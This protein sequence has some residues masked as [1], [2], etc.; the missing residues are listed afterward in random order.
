MLASAAA[1]FLQASKCDNLVEQVA[2][3]TLDA[4]ECCGVPELGTPRHNEVRVMTEHRQEERQSVRV[5]FY[6]TPEW[7]ARLDEAVEAEGLNQRGPWVRRLVER[8]LGGAD[9]P[10]IELSSDEVTLQLQLTESRAE[11]RGLQALIEQLRERLG[12]ADAHNQ[13]LNRRLEEAHSTVDRVT[14]MLPAAGQ[15]GRQWW[16]FWS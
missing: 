16:R 8:A 9:E 7:A 1:D 10:E 6:L 2:R 14:L 13:D 4:V 11:N 3:C 15:T 5:V 12:M